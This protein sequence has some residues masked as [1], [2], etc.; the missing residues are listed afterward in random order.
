MIAQQFLFHPVERGTHRGNLGYHVN[1][2]AFFIHHL[3]QAADLSFDAVEAPVAGTL[4]IGTHEF[5]IP[6]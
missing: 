1:A 6:H 3:G 4:D 5:Y 2:V